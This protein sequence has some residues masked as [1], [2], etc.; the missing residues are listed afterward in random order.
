MELKQFIKEA[1]L[2]IVDGVEDANKTHD[3]FKLIGMKHHESGIDGIYADFDVSV[4]VNEAS[5]GGVEG[6]IGVS[7]LNVVSAG[8]GSKIDQANLQ[9]N[10]HRLTFRVFIS[11]KILN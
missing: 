10:T 2:N 6:K 8:V 11:E 7:L 9:Q 3:R 4:I 1:L 5:S